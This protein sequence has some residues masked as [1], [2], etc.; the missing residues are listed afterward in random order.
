MNQKQIKIEFG[1]NKYDLPKKSRK[2]KQF[3]HKLLLRRKI[4]KNIVLL[5]W[6]EN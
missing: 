3:I 1:I 5:T 2:N 6:I 4:I